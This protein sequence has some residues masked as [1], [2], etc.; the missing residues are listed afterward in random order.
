MEQ[1]EYV[2]VYIDD[3]LVITSGT[4]EDHLR[5]VRVVLVKLQEANLK[6]NLVKSH[7]AQDEVEYLG[8]I[9]NRDGIKPMPNKVSAILAILPPR[10]VK[11]LRKFLGIIQYYRDVWEKRSELLAP[12]TDLVGECGHT[13][14]TKK[15]KTKKKPWHWDECHQKA[16]DAIKEIVAR[17]IILAYPDFSQP[18]EIYTDSSSRQM[19]AII[20]QK[21]SSN[22]VI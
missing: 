7:F 9:L 10:N 5:K 13:K 12:L 15:H 3:L 19:G 14:T 16:F 17:D 22:C 2:R 8:Y 6:V 4:Y 20:L 21:K 11:S 1:L 18:F